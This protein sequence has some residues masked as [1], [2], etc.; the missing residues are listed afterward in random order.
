MA[1]TLDDTA[2]LAATREQFDAEVA[3]LNT[4]TLG[5]PACTTRG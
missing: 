1:I 5:L 3:Y 4:A 2:R